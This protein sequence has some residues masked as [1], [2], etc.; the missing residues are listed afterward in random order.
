MTWWRRWVR[1]PQTV[2]LRRAAF[3]VHLWIGLALGLYIVMLSLT[4]SALVFRREMDA[5]FRTP[6]PEFRENATVMTTEQITARANALYPGYT[7]TFV[8][9]GVRRRN[10]VILVSMKKGDEE[11]ERL[12]N[13]YTGEDIGDSFPWK[14]RA[15]LWLVNLHDELLFDRT[16]RWW[17][18][19]LSG[20]VT[21]L[22]LTGAVVWWP[23]SMRWKRAMS[24]KWSGGWRRMNFDLHSA[25]GFWMFALM[26]VWAISGLYLGI[27]DPFTSASAYFAG[28]E[29]DGRIGRWIETTM[30]WMTRLH[31]GRWRNVPLQILWVI[32]GLAPAVLFVT[33]AVMWWQRVVR[34]RNP[35]TGAPVVKA[36]N[37][38]AQAS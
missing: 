12:F 1:Q 24:V 19:L 15:L 13:P 4:G 21:I 16:G 7:I 26:L 6:V 32:M 18:G 30:L 27:P 10:P 3:Q 28:P 38:T 37:K 11:K 35:Q 2:F 34:R 5:A 9:D 25:M 36:A 23:G 22:C 8:S 17:N 33:G 14:S 20:V 29:G 31:F